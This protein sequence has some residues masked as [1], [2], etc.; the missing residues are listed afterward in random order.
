[1]TPSY[2]CTTYYQL[3][4][5]STTTQPR[6]RRG[7]RK[8]I[9]PSYFAFLNQFPVLSSHHH[10]IDSPTPVSAALFFRFS[11]WVSLTQPRRRRRRRRKIEKKKIL[12][13][14]FAFLPFLISFPFFV[15]TSLPHSPPPVSPHRFFHFAFWVSLST[16]PLHVSPCFVFQF[17]FSTS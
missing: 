11:F 8:K 10:L 6:G 14:C 15:T 7:R 9:L 5:A 13:S 12:L 1:M 16:S 17:Q 4:T 2:T 3:V